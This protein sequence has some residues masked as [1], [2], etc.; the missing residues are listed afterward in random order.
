[1]GLEELLLNKIYETESLS[2][3]QWIKFKNTLVYPK[4][5]S[6]IYDKQKGEF[7]F[8]DFTFL[9]IYVLLL[10]FPLLVMALLDEHS[11]QLLIFVEYRPQ[12]H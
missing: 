9:H 1:M 11:Y 10:K 6:K 5:K 4:K 3:N 8:Q 12:K 2:M 7:Q